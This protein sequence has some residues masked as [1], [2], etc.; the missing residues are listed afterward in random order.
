MLRSVFKLLRVPLAEAN[1]YN[2]VKSCSPIVTKFPIKH[3]HTTSKLQKL[4][5][6]KHTV[7]TIPAPD[8]GTEG[9]K[10]VDID[11]IV[12]K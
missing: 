1:S 7:N 11:T 12:N 3:L 4:E 6:K 9:E 5:N 10:L 8:E 2:A